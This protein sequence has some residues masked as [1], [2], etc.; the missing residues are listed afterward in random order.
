MRLAALIAGLLA[1]SGC[2]PSVAG[3]V[4]DRHYKEAICAGQEGSWSTREMVGRA[5]DADAALLIH[6]HVASADELRAVLGGSTDQVLERA[7]LV[8]VSAQSNVLPIDALG[9]HAAFMTGRGQR[10]AVI[11]NWTTLAWLT[12]E[13]LP[14]KRVE[15]TYVTGE[16]VLK[17]GAAVLTLGLSLLFTDFEPGYVEVDAPLSE[18]ERIAPL[19]SRLHRTTERGGCLDITLSA[20]G[21]GQRCTWYFLV[22]NISRAPVS[23]EL[24]TRYVA[25]RVGIESGTTEELTCVIERR[26]EFAL[27]PP[28]GMEAVV[29]ESFG[30]EMRFVRDVMREVRG[31]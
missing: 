30:G 1:L 4:K 28:P 15:E 9:I 3:L 11:A 20:S 6:A 18:F 13:K 31:P 17:G 23:L 12:Q 16:N 27:G 2:G 5:L 8:R 29:K 19:A 22:D 26:Y 24:T 14:P 7:R 10:A 25:Q 21:A